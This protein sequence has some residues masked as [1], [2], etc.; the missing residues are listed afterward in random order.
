MSNR[1]PYL[2]GLG[3]G[4]IVGSIVLQLGGIGQTAAERDA[5]GQP[6]GGASETLA[7]M[8]VE[9]LRTAA[10]LNGYKLY[11]A[12]EVWFSEEEALAMAA[13]AEERGKLA[14]EAEAAAN[15]KANPA[16]P[17]QSRIVYAFTVGSGT[18]LITVARLVYELG[19]VDDYNAFLQA[20][21]ERKLS[22]RIQAKHH[23]F[24]AVPT[25]DDLIEALISH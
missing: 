3:T 9:Q 5:S 21:E 20:M 23:R 4:L 8:P 22:G 6:N 10:E 19:L 11:D 13:E 24:D 17:Q 25:M 15:G 18:D 12:A 1:R 2:Y 14:A 16:D 7:D